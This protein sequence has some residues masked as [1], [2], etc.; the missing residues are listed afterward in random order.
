MPVEA[1]PAPSVGSVTPPQPAQINVPSAP[2][3]PDPSKSSSMRESLTQRVLSS[4]KLQSKL[5]AAKTPDAPKPAEKPPEVPKSKES[6]NPGQPRPEDGK[7]VE[8][9]E[10]DTAK[11]S[12]AT[13]S[14]P[15]GGKQMGPWQLK[16]LAEDRAI[17]AETKYAKL[18]E[19][20]GG[21]EQEVTARTERLTK[22]EQR[23]KELEDEIR[24]VNYVKSSEFREKFQAPYER[25]IQSAM[26]ELAGLTYQDG[27]GQ[28]REIS[29]D[30]LMDFVSR[31]AAQARAAA[32][33]LFGDSANDV[34]TQRGLI[35]DKLDQQMA[36]I[37][38][39][40]KNGSQRDQQRM[41][42]RQAFMRETSTQANQWWEEYNKQVSE[43]PEHGEFIKPREG[44]AEW[45]SA[46]ERGFESAKKAFSLNIMDP[47]L[48]PDQR[49]EAVKQ[50]AALYNKAAAYSTQRLEIK[51]LR[52]QLA[53]A[54]SE[55][56]KYQDTTPGTGGS[57]AQAPTAPA[58]GFSR[59]EQVLISKSKPRMY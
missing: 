45:N 25:S 26:K 7:S 55:L 14:K 24:H 22:A 33:Q 34:M 37:E 52:K 40:K 4:P 10:S 56:K 48:T 29:L 53:D 5:P 19:S 1:P 59:L 54:Q 58:N 20:I 41:E 50:Q 18:L 6:P 23:A 3:N 35:R 11:T 27:A 39:A 8:S 9:V 32:Q 57:P 28:A 13:D 36:A 43:H 2:T 17:A 21:S 15:A 46:L 31:P 30:L 16:K 42:S 38:D 47:R 12:P 49:K 44:N 51:S